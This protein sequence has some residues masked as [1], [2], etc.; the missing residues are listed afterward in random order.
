M[1]IAPSAD[2]VSIWS[3]E[4]FGGQQADRVHEFLSRT[5][6]VA[7]VDSVELRRAKE[8]GR[9]H[10]RAVANPRR[11]WKKLSR[12]L[13]Q[14][15][16]SPSPSEAEVGP[17]RGVD[18]GLLY[19]NRPAAEPI[20]VSRLGSGL[21]TWRVRHQSEDSLQL[22]HPALRHR[23]EVVFR[24]EEELATIL[25]VEDFRV[26][27]LT[28]EVAIR[29]DRAA[30][31]VDHLGRELEKAW[32]RL[33]EGLEGPP[34]R[35]RFIAATAL[36]ALA[37]TGQYLVPV[38]RPL[39]V[40]A[41]LVYSAPNLVAGL[42]QLARGQVGVY[43]LYTVG[44]GFTLASGMPFASAAITVLM[45]FWPRLAR[46]KFVSSQR[47]LFASQRRRQIWARTA[48]GNDTYLQVP[49][50][51]VRPD[52]LVVVRS[53]ETV[54]VD[55]FVQEGAAA[56][57]AGVP[58]NRDGSAV[59]QRASGDWIGAGTFIRAGHL[60]IRVERVRDTATSYLASLLPHAPLPRMPS[61]DEVE[62]VA[63]RNAKP[64]LAVA[65]LNLALTRTRRASQAVLRPDYV[66]GPRLSAHLSALRAL[67]EAAQQGI[68]FRNPAALDR[69]AGA[70]VFIFDESAGLDRR[71]AEVAAVHPAKGVDEKVVAA[72]ARA[73]LERHD[74]RDGAALALE[75]FTADSTTLRPKREQVRQHAGVARYRDRSGD[76]IEVATA[77]YIVA[78]D[79][80]VPGGLRQALAKGPQQSD[81]PDEAAALRP[82]WVL[83]NGQLLGVVSFAHTGERVGKQ[84][85][86]ALKAQHPRARLVYLGRRSV[87]DTQALARELEIELGYGGLAPAARAELIRGVRRATIWVGDGTEAS[88]REAI[89]ASTV[90]VSTAA[91]R[92]AP[93][94]LADVL[95]TSQGL[96]GLAALVGL[97]QAH[98]SRLATDYRTVYAANL[99]GVA[100]AFTS[101]LGA[102]Q[103]GLL[104]NL[105][106]G[107]VFARHALALN[108]LAS[109]VEDQRTSPV[110]AARAR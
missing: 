63:N 60:T 89:A 11:I 36:L 28:G 92:R 103:T 39:A 68:Y 82:L 109:A 106:T 85:I 77:H 1:R 31:T 90:S 27:G 25:G 51:D 41:Y 6:L 9:I 99:T 21:S 96:N 18:V 23:R 104:S 52:D 95:L 22:W 76:L 42:K 15:T 30:L 100:G 35:T 29:F 65:A 4:I 83:K 97:A 80:S 13:S 98:Q 94:D 8:F 43:V 14:L 50:D 3:A 34:P 2:G 5:F 64:T 24:L 54:P 61:L 56:V 55:G 12:V 81:A 67:G 110:G 7:E 26:S 37:F 74:Q 16:D 71:R 105:G 73:A 69:L 38:V 72:Y 47:R 79:L 87:A 108:R 88:A 93:D 10:H 49:L 19:L 75:A 101:R 40:G 45:Q 32:P 17:V 20:H 44:L 53:G 78:S 46:R 58:F 91:V 62:R 107:V 84:T 33:L 102:L 70:D 48:K 66:T 86:A 59:E 57:V